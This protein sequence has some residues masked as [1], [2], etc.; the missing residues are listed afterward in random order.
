MHDSFYC[1]QEINHTSFFLLPALGIGV[2]HQARTTFLPL[3]FYLLFIQ[4]LFAAFLACYIIV[5]S[6]VPLP[7]LTVVIILKSTKFP[8][9][10]PQFREIPITDASN[11][12]ALKPTSSAFDC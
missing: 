9:N 4:P 8:K 6:F 10:K 11:I 7:L 2:E 5:Q 1:L 3:Q 12:Y